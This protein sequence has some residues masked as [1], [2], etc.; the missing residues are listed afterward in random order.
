MD[1]RHNLRPELMPPYTAK[2]GSTANPAPRRVL[3]LLPLCQIYFHRA[4]YRWVSVGG[5]VVK[6]TPAVGDHAGVPPVSLLL[7][8]VHNCPLML[9]NSFPRQ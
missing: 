1:S 9:L 6:P 5:S 3:F 8:S 7:Y 4:P 2:C